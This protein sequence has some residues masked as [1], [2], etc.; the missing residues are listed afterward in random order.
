MGPKFGAS[1][2]GLPGATTGPGAG[3][4]NLQLI[5]HSIYLRQRPPRRLPAG[6][7]VGVAPRHRD[8]S[9]GRGGEEGVALEGEL[10][11]DFRQ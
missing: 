3:A 9:C 1:S 5:L 8:A 11:V 2:G 6:P 7:A 4:G 10:A